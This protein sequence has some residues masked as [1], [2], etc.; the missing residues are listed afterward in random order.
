MS[1]SSVFTVADAEGGA[2]ADGGAAG[3]DGGARL[4]E[5]PGLRIP[6][7]AVPRLPTPVASRRTPMR[8]RPDVADETSGESSGVNPVIWVVGGLAV[9]LIGGAFVLLRRG[10]GSGS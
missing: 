10:G 8:P 2:G 7:L 6:M 1:G 4:R 3:A 5:V 9:L